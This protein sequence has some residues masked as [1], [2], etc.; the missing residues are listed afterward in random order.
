MH[1]QRGDGSAWQP[2]GG[3]GLSP[4]LLPAQPAIA[5][6]EGQDPP[7]SGAFTLARVGVPEHG[8]GGAAAR[9]PQSPGQ[10]VRAARWRPGALIGGGHCGGR[11]LPSRRLGV[12]AAGGSLP[13]A[14]AAGGRPGGPVSPCIATL[15]GSG[16]SRSPMP[17]P[18]TAQMTSSSSSLTLAG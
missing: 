1:G 6:L 13:P 8:A 3:F 11:V 4:G 9:A 7:A 18:T 17:Q 12:T 10:A 5:A 2:A 15:P 14:D 16:M